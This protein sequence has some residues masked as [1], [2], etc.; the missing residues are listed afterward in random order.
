MI[1]CGSFRF[2]YGRDPRQRFRHTTPAIG[3][4]LEQNPRIPFHVTPTSTSSMN[5]A[6]TGF[7]ILTRGRSDVD[8]RGDDPQQAQDLVSVGAG[9]RSLR[10]DRPSFREPAQ[11]PL[12]VGLR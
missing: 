9:E 6:E 5:E 7:G 8:G 12:R 10:V 11:D 4:R 2:R 3:T 1:G